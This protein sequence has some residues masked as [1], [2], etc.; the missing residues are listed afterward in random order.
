LTT[1]S[2]ITR[3]PERLRVIHEVDEVAEAAVFVVDVASS[4][5]DATGWFLLR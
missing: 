3:T 1:R 2:T 4:N 5:A